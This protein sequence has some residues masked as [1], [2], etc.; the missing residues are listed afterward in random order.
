M[1]RLFLLFHGRFPSEK[2]A[3]LFAAKSAAAFAKQGLDVTL[4]VPRRK[5]VDTTDPFSFYSLEKNFSIEYLPT[6]DLFS[7]KGFHFF[8]FWA[9][10]IAFSLSSYRYLKQHSATADI[11]YSNESLP[12]FFASKIRPNCLYEMHDFPESKIGLFKKFLSRMK[13][14]LV[15]NKW[16]LE[17]IQKLCP[18][19]P[20]EKFLY[21]PNAVDIKA[22]DIKMIK[23]EARLKLSLPIHKKIAVYTGHLYG[24]K[25]VDTLAAAAKLLPEQFLVVFVGGTVGDVEKFKTVYGTISNIIITG[26]KP[27]DEIPFWQKSADVLVL[28]NTAKE[29]ISAYYTSPMKL[30]EYMASGRPLIA[31]DIPSIREIVDEQSAVLVAPDDAQALAQAIENITRTEQ[32]G[33]DLAKQ[34][35]AKVQGHTWDQ[36]ARRIL[37]FMNIA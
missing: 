28:P 33:D 30:Y 2:A 21:E 17:E 31:S 24:W 34:A 29:K 19:I 14:I 37:D 27:H 36:R 18:E 16:K 12:L 15:H 1:T 6:I 32:I 4:L 23:E 25:G 20:G 26:F 8:A 11:I 3:A 35:Y 10:F 5:G 13:W 7:L 22:F 9:S